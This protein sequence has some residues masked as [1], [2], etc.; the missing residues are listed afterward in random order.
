M[1]SDMGVN[2]EDLKAKAGAAGATGSQSEDKPSQES[3]K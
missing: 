1:F 2:M 3:F